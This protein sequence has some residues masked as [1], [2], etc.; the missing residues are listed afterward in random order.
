MQGGSDTPWSYLLIR[1]LFKFVLKIFYGTI[2]VEGTENIPERGKPW[3]VYF[4]FT[5]AILL[6]FVL[7][8]Q[9]CLC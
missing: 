9:Y 6:T 3:Y 8:I 1:L 2:V 5:Y 4:I 7:T